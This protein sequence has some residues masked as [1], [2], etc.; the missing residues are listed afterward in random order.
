MGPDPPNASPGNSHHRGRLSAT[1]TI[2]L[3]IAFGLRAGYFDNLTTD[4]AEQTDLINAPYGREQVEGLRR[5]LLD[6]LDTEPGAAEVEH[7]YLDRF[8]RALSDA[9]EQSSSRRIA[10]V[11]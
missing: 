7:A 3:A 8:R 1:T 2:L 9:I 6:A 5:K 11:R 4:P 10:K